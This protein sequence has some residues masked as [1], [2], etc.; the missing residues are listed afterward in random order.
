MSAQLQ[1]TD[2]SQHEALAGLDA[3]RQLL[4]LLEEKK[5]R[6]ETNAL[7]FYTPYPKQRTFHAAGAMKRERML[8]AG[9]QQ[10]KTL[11]AGAEFA[12]H[13]T[14]QYPDWWT[15]KRFDRPIAAWASGVTGESTRDNPQRI[16]LGRVGREG[17]GWIPKDC[18]ISIK[19]ARGTADAVD[20][21]LVR[22]AS[23]GISQL[24]F[25][26]YEKGREKWQGESLD[27][28]WFD[29]EPPIDIYMEGM[30]RTNATRGIIMITFTPLLG[31]S[32]VV[33]RYLMEPSDDRIVVSM[34]IHDALHYSEEERQ[35][36]IDSYPEH[37]RDARAMGVPI[38][39]S[40]RIF[41]VAEDSIKIPAPNIPSH[42]PR[43]V[44][45][46]FGW[47]HPTAAAWLAWDRDLDVVYVYDA[48]RVRK[49]KALV[50]AAAIRARGSWI[51]VAW[52]HD[53]LQHDKGAGEQLA[54]QYRSHGLNMLHERAQYEETES[55]NETQN[56][57]FSVEAGV[58]DMLDR[59][60]TRRLLVAEHLHDWFEEF[61]LYHRK[62]GKIVKENDDLI[63]A[64]RYGIMMLRYAATNTT[65][66]MPNPHRRRAGLI[67]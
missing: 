28:V 23:G 41:P 15:G 49:E 40:G 61:R 42:W 29:E 43:I 1:P 56:S 9:N 46:D 53:G 57:R 36:I 14:G 7:R 52:P 18:I 67:S 66:K 6:R 27:L 60:Q 35:R 30:T 59:M 32:D 8:K 20:T 51:P 31:I 19:A 11:G 16:L 44:G 4:K 47:D 39:G 10:G 3:R 48:Y 25:K 64:T 33:R 17:T 38:L 37:E 22:H 62:D 65:I 2:L 54:E 24:Q 63:S 21:V 12:M 26:S 58:S 50:H 5:R 55:E 13:L 34:T 45:I